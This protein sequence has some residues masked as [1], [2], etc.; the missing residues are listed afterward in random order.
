MTLNGISVLRKVLLYSVRGQTLPGAIS[1]SSL[2]SEVR[3]IGWVPRAGLS[4][5]AIHT[6]R[7]CQHLQA[8]K[9]RAPT[10]PSD[11]Q[12]CSEKI[13]SQDPDPPFHPSLR[14]QRK[15]RAETGKSLSGS[16]EG[17]MV[18]KHSESCSSFTALRQPH[19]KSH[20]VSSLPWPST[21][22]GA[23]PA[24]TNIVGPDTLGFAVLQDI[25]VSG[26]SSK[27]LAPHETPRFTQPADRTLCQRLR[28]AAAVAE[29]SNG[30]E[31][32][33]PQQL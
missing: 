29:D 27:D 31:V 19:Q 17:T 15:R 5:Q 21:A 13:R 9:K 2:L 6:S 3:G 18:S 20:C 8:W 1:V 25:R 33:T 7:S 4:P 30:D 11:Q 28:G 16:Y 10:C 22:F 24:G 14:F 23:V 12:G 26:L 32:H